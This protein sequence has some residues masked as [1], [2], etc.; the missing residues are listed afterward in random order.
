VTQPEDRGIFLKDIIEDIPMDDERWNKM[1]EKYLT[2]K[3]MEK[4]QQ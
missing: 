2:E 1:D 4:I 3:A